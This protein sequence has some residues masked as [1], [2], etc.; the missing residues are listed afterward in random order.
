MPF[1]IV[2]G[3]PGYINLLDAMNAWQL[4]KELKKGQSLFLHLTTDDS[5][6]IFV[7]QRPASLPLLLSSTFHLPV[8]LLACP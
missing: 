7:A 6:D 2:N 4:V 5:I 3:K 1:K 8:P